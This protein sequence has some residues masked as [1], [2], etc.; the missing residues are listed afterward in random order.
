MPSKDVC[1]DGGKVPV[2]K[3][4]YEILGVESSIV[5][6]KSTKEAKEVSKNT[7]TGFTVFTLHVKIG[8]ADRETVTDKFREGETKFLIRTDVLARVVDV[9][10]VSVV[11][12]YTIPKS[13]EYRRAPVV[14]IYLHRVGHKASHQTWICDHIYRRRTGQEIFGENRGRVQPS[15]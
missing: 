14:E 5:F 3:D 15:W 13:K 4:V 8:G 7:L 10:G 12:N 6:L 2:F 9:P 11:V 1:T